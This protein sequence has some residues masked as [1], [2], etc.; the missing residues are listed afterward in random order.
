VVS[1]VLSKTVLKGEASALT[2]GL[3]PYH[4]PKGGAHPVHLTDRSHHLRV[5]ARYPAGEAGRCSDLDP[6]Q[7]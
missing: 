2:L 4:R 5:V 7:Y 1:W 6:G 3:P